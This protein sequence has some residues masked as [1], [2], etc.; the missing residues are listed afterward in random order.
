MLLR[1]ITDPL[2]AQYAYLIGCQRTKEALIIDPERDIDRYVAAAEAEGLTIRHVAETHIHADY[3][4][5]ARQFA[6]EH[7]VTL[8]LSDEGGSDWSYEWARESDYEIRLL[9]N[10]DVFHV[11]NIEV[12]AV[13]TPGHTPEHLSFLIT[14]HGGG[15]E[16]PMG[17]VTGDF[18]FVGDLGRPDLLE[19][20]A[21]HASAAE[22]AA[23]QLYGSV[24][25]LE[26]LPEYLQVWPGHGAG[27]A[28]GKALGAVPQTTV[29]YEM[30]HNAALDAARAGEEPFVS[31]ILEGQPEP[32]LYFKRMKELN[33]SG[34]PLLSAL[35]TP[36][37][38]SA[39]DLDELANRDDIAVV[40]TRDRQIYIRGHLPG[41]IL[42]PLDNQF[43]TIAG[44]FVFPD[45]P[46]YLVIGEDDLER[47]IRALVRIGLDDV[48]GYL[49]PE[50]LKEWGEGTGRLRM[51]KEIDFDEVDGRRHYTNVQVVDVRRKDEWD[52]KHIPEAVHIPHVRL[53]EHIDEL[54]RDKTLLVHCAAGARSAAAAA[55]LHNRGF[56][57]AYVGDRF[58]N[59]KERHRQPG[60][61]AGA[62]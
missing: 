26:K 15:G 18:L 35:P 28:C 44:S 8:Y 27:S 36:R 39:S 43:P 2:L 52:V 34:P 33:R 41:S 3:L 54:P 46:I 19:T 20:A 17:V 59:W 38:L 58:E 60:V 31:H 50:T 29:G 22:P 30:R 49:T 48:R 55:Y 5:G 37:Q 11:G 14:D 47:A 45:E 21:G 25:L 12:K 57:V 62:H 40:D 13:H 61:T 42:I 6:E 32:P 16:E 56:S 53:R 9:R 7:D 51:L 10:G 24:R 4:S 1:Q 23:R